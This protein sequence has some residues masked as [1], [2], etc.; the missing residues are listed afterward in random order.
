MD[1]TLLLLRWAHLLA[2]II[3]VGGLAFARF[4]L[5]PAIAEFDEETRIARVGRRVSPDR[6]GR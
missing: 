4:G 2:A 6:R 1:P 3:A 5:L